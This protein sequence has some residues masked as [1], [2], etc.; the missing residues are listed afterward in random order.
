MDLQDWWHAWR[1]RLL[2]LGGVAVILLGGV[3]WPPGEIGL[4]DIVLGLTWILW[5]ARLQS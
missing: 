5:G 4:T 3:Q 2:M 1:G